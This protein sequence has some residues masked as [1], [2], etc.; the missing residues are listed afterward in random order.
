M[1]QPWSHY[2]RVVIETYEARKSGKKSRLHAR[3]IDGQ[4]FPPNMDVECSRAMRERHAVGTRF[5]VYAKET[6]KEGGK[7]FLYTHFSWP[8]E[9]VE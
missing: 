4:P 2:Q 5:R 1:A 8:Y 3:P 6:D 9:V 7:P